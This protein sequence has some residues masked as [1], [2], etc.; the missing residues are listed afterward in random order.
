MDFK[1]YQIEAL[2]TFKPG[3]TSEQK[4]LYCS[5]K[6]AEE[7]GE[8]T[9]PLAKNIVHGKPLP[10]QHVINEL[11]DILYYIAILAD[12]YKLDL[13]SIA[14]FNIDK[15]RKRHGTSYNSSHYK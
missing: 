6:L 9:G 7:V 2:K 8:T 11:G 4:I 5:V 10:D 15:L 3:L 12:E 14:Q 13:E 1:E